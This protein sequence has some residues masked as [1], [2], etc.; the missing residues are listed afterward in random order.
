MGAS[1][2]CGERPAYTL[3]GGNKYI[4]ML[5]LEGSWVSE[6]MVLLGIL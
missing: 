6:G 2:R 5:Q 4:T 3:G 1:G